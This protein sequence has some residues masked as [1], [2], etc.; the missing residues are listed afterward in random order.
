MT[1][2]MSETELVR[3]ESLETAVN[4]ALEEW[5]FRHRAPEQSYL[6][7]YRNAASVVIG[8][9][10]NP[11]LEC[12]LPVMRELGVEFAR[13]ASGGGAVYH[14]P[15]NLNYS[16][17]LPRTAYDPAR[18]VGVVRAALQSLG[19]DA[20]QCERHAVWVA[21]RK[22]SGSAFMLTGKSAM[23]HGCLLIDSDLA[24]LGGCLTAPGAETITA[25]S[26]R[27]VPS[28]VANLREFRQDLDHELLAEAI[29]ASYRA[30]VGPVQPW[31]TRLADLE[32]LP[33]YEE[34]LGKYR[35]AEWLYERTPEFRQQLA[36]TFDWGRVEL[37]LTVVG[38]RV[39]DVR[40]DVS[41]SCSELTDR[42]SAA[43]QSRPYGMG[44]LA[45]SLRALADSVP[46]GRERLTD[47]GDWLERH[48]VQPGMV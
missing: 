23:L 43:L 20:S 17:I 41:P 18:F 30:S 33:E 15:G 6:M 13:R 42:I 39:S 35:T 32:A 19:I 8:R 24:A 37:G 48:A 11:W 34:Y 38:G 45:A 22:V 3:S 5:L 40:C 44:A 9:N 12:N 36:G 21:G 26:V 46:E 2:V 10:Q 28:P 27:S 1:L 25:K 29:V 31:Q 4:L 14:D 7:F 47:V 16:F